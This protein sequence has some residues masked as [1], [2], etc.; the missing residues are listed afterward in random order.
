MNKEQFDIFLEGFE[1]KKGTPEPTKVEPLTMDTI[2]EM[3]AA[4]INGR[5]DEVKR[6]LQG[7]E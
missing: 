1:G 7:L 2:K 4:E 6:V 5:W 3:T